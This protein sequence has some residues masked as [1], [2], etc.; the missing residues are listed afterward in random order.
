LP[1]EGVFDWHYLQCVVRA[2]GTP[3]YQNFPNINFFVH[4]FK[5]AHDD[6]D[7]DDEYTDNDEAELPYPSYRFDRYLEEQG[8]RQMALE[9]REAVGRWSSGI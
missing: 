3:Q 2:F 4:P 8:R 1:P 6:D 7:S 9:R 5:T